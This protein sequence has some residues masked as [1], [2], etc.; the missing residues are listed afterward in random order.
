M[1]TDYKKF[2]RPALT[3]SNRAALAYCLKLSEQGF[4]QEI[5]QILEDE[6]EGSVAIQIAAETYKTGSSYMRNLIRWHL[7]REAS[8]KRKKRAAKKHGH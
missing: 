6:G 5:E 3:H 8:R 1:T 7:S 2:R 4:E